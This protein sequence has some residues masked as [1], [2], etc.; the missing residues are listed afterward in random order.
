MAATRASPASV[1]I[2]TPST[3]STF[4][5]ADG[6]MLSDPAPNAENTKITSSTLPVESIED[7]H[8]AARPSSSRTRRTSAS[9]GDACDSRLYGPHLERLPEGH[10]HA[11][12]QVDE[13]LA[14]AL[15]LVRRAFHRAPYR[16]SAGVRPV[17]LRPRSRRPVW[18]LA[19]LSSRRFLRLLQET[20]KGSSEFIQLEVPLVPPRADRGQATRAHLARFVGEICRPS[21][22]RANRTRSSSLGHFLATFV[23]FQNHSPS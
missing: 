21:V 20:A 23:I 15:A 11:E 7:L 3:L 10:R 18:H 14:G 16:F 5:P 8:L 19:I 9:G 22:E 13:R 17:S 2:N 6:P 4:P 1:H 12:V